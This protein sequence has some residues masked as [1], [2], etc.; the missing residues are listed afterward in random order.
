MAVL[1]LSCINHL[2]PPILQ[3]HHNTQIPAQIFLAKPCFPL[4]LITASY[5]PPAATR[6]RR[7]C[8]AM[9]LCP[10]RNL[11]FVHMP[12][13]RA[14]VHDASPHR[15][16]RARAHAHARQAAAATAARA[17]GRRAEEGIKPAKGHIA[18][19]GLITTERAS[20]GPCRSQARAQ[21][22]HP[23]HIQHVRTIDSPAP[24]PT[25]PTVPVKTESRFVHVSPV[26]VDAARASDS[27]SDQTRPPF[28]LR[29]PRLRPVRPRS[30]SLF[31]L[32]QFILPLRL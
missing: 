13:R 15:R 26:L 16:T 27:D 5:R 6:R 17:P 11:P 2:L 21:D 8:H 29:D 4:F 31:R 30:F 28:C 18:G 3:T 10:G 1:A 25:R 23:P 22:L 24:R 19:A 12:A 9:S 20:D 32:I 7:P 14:P